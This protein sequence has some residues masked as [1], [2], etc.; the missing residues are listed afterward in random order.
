MIDVDKVFSILGAVNLKVNV[1][2]CRFAKDKFKVL[3][4]IISQ[5]GVLSDLVKVKEISK[6]S[7]PTDITGV[8][9]FK[10]VI[11]LFC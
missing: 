2:K 1:M 5:D 6:F 4:Y 9:R 8:K 11:N 10:K 3:G 7:P